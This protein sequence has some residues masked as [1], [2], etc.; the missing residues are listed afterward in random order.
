M[1]QEF[2]GQHSNPPTGNHSY[3]DPS[4]HNVFDAIY[5]GQSDSKL[6]NQQSTERVNPISEKLF[7]IA[8]CIAEARKD[9]L[10]RQ[11][12]VYS[13]KKG[14]FI[15]SVTGLLFN[16]DQAPRQL[17]S[18]TETDL[19]TWESELGATIFG[20]IK[21][22][23]H[24]N[25]FYETRS[26]DGRD[27]WFFDQIITDVAGNEHRVT[28]H[29]EVHPGQKGVLKVVSKPGQRNEYS[30]VEGKELDNFL[31][32]CNTYR[33]FVKRQLYGNDNHIDDIYRL[34]SSDGQTDQRFRLN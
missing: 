3:S 26:E 4:I 19:M 18:L 15:N 17:E 25:F 20:E 1:S 23:E 5:Q 13:D 10:F 22:N 24:R 12:F 9:R 33:D 16:R 2:T 7:G 31:V 27:S 8:D 34:H 11:F 32:A 14:N 28:H 6:A 29:Y 30:F 21:P